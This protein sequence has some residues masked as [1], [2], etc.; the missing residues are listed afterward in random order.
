MFSVCNAHPAVTGAF[1]T[2]PPL[3]KI[4]VNFLPQIVSSLPIASYPDFV[5]GG[6]GAATVADV[7]PPMGEL[8]TGRRKGP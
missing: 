3:L 6:S 8:G 7:A 1:A 5:L 4:C 2:D